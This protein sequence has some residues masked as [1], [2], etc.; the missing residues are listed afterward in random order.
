MSA[1]VMVAIGVGVEALV[2]GEPQADSTNVPTIS[3]NPSEKARGVRMSY[4]LNNL[5][6]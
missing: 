4:F 1:I 2:F 5:N 3:S 6:L